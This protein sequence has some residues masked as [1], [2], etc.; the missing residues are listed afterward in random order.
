[1]SNIPPKP[2]QDISMYFPCLCLSLLCLFS[3]HCPYLFPCL[4]SHPLLFPSLFIISLSSSGPLL[5]TMLAVG[6]F[7]PLLLL[8]V[9]CCR[10]TE[11]P[12]D[13]SAEFWVRLYHQLQMAG[14]DDNIIFSPLSVALAL[15]MVGLGARGSSL[16]Q[17]RQAL[18]YAQYRDG[19]E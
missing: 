15:G 10:A 19:K 5:S 2:I 13:A 1:M 12:E 8:R 11:V 18:G 7:V 9:C 3:S 6:L 14:T 4:S 17:I 16:Q